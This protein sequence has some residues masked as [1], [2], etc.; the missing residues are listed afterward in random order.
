MRA[1]GTTGWI[2]LLLIT[3]SVLGTTLYLTTWST[4]II[5][6]LGALA[7]AC[8]VTADWLLSRRRP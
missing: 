7:G 6:A 1:I 5:L 2:M 3:W 8:I 4:P